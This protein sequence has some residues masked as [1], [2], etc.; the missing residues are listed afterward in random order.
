MGDSRVTL[1]TRCHA[2]V[3]WLNSM[4]VRLVKDG[5]GCICWGTT[6]GCSQDVY[7]AR[8]VSHHWQVLQYH[9]RS[10]HHPHNRVLHC[11]LA[12]TSTAATPFTLRNL[13]WKQ[14]SNIISSIRSF[15]ILACI[16]S[17]ETGSFRSVHFSVG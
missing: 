8:G 6:L 9:R 2:L 16:T 1:I 10:S 5:M 13:F 3:R 4:R 11:Q 7:P 14:Y 12:G 15:N 17:T